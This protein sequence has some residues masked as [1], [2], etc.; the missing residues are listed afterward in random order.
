MRTNKWCNPNIITLILITAAACM[1]LHA[2][3]M[4]MPVDLS[5]LAQRADVIVQGKVLEVKEEGLPGYPNFPTILVT[6]EVEN[7]MRGPAK[8]TTYTFR[9]AALGGRKSYKEKLGYKEGQRMLL[10]LPSPSP[11]GLSSPIGV[12]QGRF[13]I[14]RDSAGAETIVNEAG[15]AGLFKN[16]A[17]KA[18]KAGKTLTTEQARVAA[19]KNGP[20]RLKEFLSL[21]KNLTSMPRIR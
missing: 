16:V 13:H 19:I 20:A 21:T 15:N 11:M 3:P 9:E 4:T 10:F 14:T 2:Q 7:M 6:L 1:P 18:A 12:G 17:Q 8:T 5:Y